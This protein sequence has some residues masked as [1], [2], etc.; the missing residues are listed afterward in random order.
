MR[1]AVAH[2]HPTPDPRRK[3]NL[4]TAWVLFSIALTFFGGIILAQGAGHTLIGIG[5]LGFGVVAFLL[6]AIGR[7]LRG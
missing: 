7:N 1:A 5:A 4:R 6:L 2:D 3:A